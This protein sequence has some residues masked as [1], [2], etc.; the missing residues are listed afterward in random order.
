M[1]VVEV[2]PLSLLPPNVPQVLSYYYDFPLTKGAMVEVM[3]NKRRMQ[4]IVIGSSEIDKQKALLKKSFFQLKQISKV[5]NPEPQVF[6]FQFKIAL[7]IAH[8]YV[9]PLGATLK[10]VLPPFFGKKK[11]P[12][13]PIP[14]LSRKFEKRPLAI[15]SRAKDSIHA[16]RDHVAS[17]QGQT[18]II[19]PEMSYINFFKNK[20]REAEVITSATANGEF[21]KVWQSA[22]GN[23]KN[24][25]IGTR[26]ALFLPFANLENLIVIDPHHEFYKSDLTPKY[27]APDL[28]GMVADLYGAQG[29]VISNLL[30]VSGFQ[31]KQ[32]LKIVTD[33]RQTRWNS[34][35]EIVDLIAE[36]KQGYF[37]IFA[38]SVRDNLYRAIEDKK[39]ILIYASRRGYQGI[40]V[41][42]NC[43]FI[44]KCPQCSNPF[45][46]HQSI[47]MVLMCHHDG[48]SQPYPD[49]C[50][51]CHSSNIKPTGPAGSQKIFEELQK[52]MEY[53]KIPRTQVLILDADVTQNQTEE[54]EIMDT[55]KSKSPIILIATQKVFSYIYDLDFDY[56]VIP[57]FDALTSSADFQTTERLYYQLEKLADFNPELVSVQTYQKQE[58]LPQVS[59][60]QYRQIYEDELKTREIFAYPPFSRIVKLTYTHNSLAKVRA[61]G[62]IAIEKLKMAKAHLQIKPSVRISESSP[63]FIKKEKG[64]YIYTIIIKIL[65][66]LKN[67]REFLHFVPAHWLI[68]VDPRSIV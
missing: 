20:L 57:Q 36:M 64:E 18:L 43:G 3:V 13:G 12:V 26:Q 65:P 17:S 35:F 32:N 16:V 54:D 2:I 4:A 25:F 24:I 68:D 41:C 63:M 48:T 7:W 66:D 53:G 46:I 1:F 45:R 8:E 67:L 10:H 55:V 5:L 59:Q 23:N 22:A 37:G 28:A 9:A 34:E 19:V 21:Y 11:Y 27:K 29:I 31:A 15:L 52:M 61:E 42:Q 50:P 6:D 38:N 56:I 60:H 49:F 40:L 39:K 58:Q 14:N 30:G 33:N 62:R 47:G 44:L 51:N